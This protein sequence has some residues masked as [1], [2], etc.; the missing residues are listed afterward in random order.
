MA[1]LPPQGAPLIAYQKYLRAEFAERGF[2]EESTEQKFMLLA[3]EFA[4]F[5]K[6]IRKQKSIKVA[7]DSQTRNLAE[8]CGDV[9]ILFL[10]IC[11]ELGL[12]AER[13]LRDKETQNKLR[14]RS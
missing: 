3:E 6:A 11:N 2:N 9:L 5:A 1:E 8:E 4:E 13:A 10:D 12:D 7:A 14:S